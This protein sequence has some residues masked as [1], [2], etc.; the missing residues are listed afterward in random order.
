MEAKIRQVWNPQIYDLYAASESIAMA[1]KPPGQAAWKVLNELQLIEVL[2]AANRQVGAGEIGRTVLTNWTNRVLPLIRY[3]LTDYVICGDTRPGHRT[4]RGFV[5]R[6]YDVLPIRLDDGRA[7]E[8]PSYGLAEFGIAGLEAFQF[9]SLSPDEVEVHYRAGEDL[10]GPLQAEMARLLATWGGT[11]TRFSQRR[12]E[13]LWNDYE[14]CKLNLVRHPDQ[15]QIGLA[16]PI[17]IPNPAVVPAAGLRPGGGFTGFPRTRLEESI[18]AVF[19][20]QVASRPDATAITEGALRLTY[21]ELNRLAN[22]AAHALRASGLELAHPVLLLFHHQA[23]MITAMLGVLKAGACYVPLDPSHPSARNTAILRE[24]GASRVLTDD[25]SLDSARSYGF[26]AAQIINMDRLDQSLADANLGLAIP[27]DAPACILHTSGTICQY[28]MNNQSR[29]AESR[30]P[31]GFAVQ[32]KELRLLDDE[33]RQVAD[34]ATGEMVVASAYLGPGACGPA[35]LAAAPP[36]GRMRVIHTGDLAYRTRDGC[37]VLVGRK[38]WQIKLRGQR[39]NLLEIEQALLTLE[40]VAAA[41]VILQ[42]GEDGAAFL[43]AFV[44]AKAAPAPAA[45]ALRRGLRA[46]LPEAMIPAVFLFPDP[47]PRTAGGK[48]D[49]QALPAAKRG[50]AA[51]QRVAGA[52]LTPTELALAEIW[53]DLLGTERIGADDGF[54]DLGGDS[55]QAAV[56]MV[57]LEARFH[58]RLPLAALIQHGTLRGLAGELA[59]DER[60][61][62]HG[63]LV[64]IQPLGDYPPV[65]LFPGSDGEVLE[66]RKMVALLGTRH[67]LY[68]LSGGDFGDLVGNSKSIEQTAAQYVI[69]IQA[70]RPCGPYI[71]AWDSTPERALP[72][73]IGWSG[74]GRFDSV[75]GGIL[76]ARWR[77][78][79]AGLPRGGIDVWL[80]HAMHLRFS[81]QELATLVEMVSLAANVASWN[82][83]ESA[84]TQIATYEALESKILER[85][86]QAGLG[87]W[88]E[89]DEEKQMF[90]VRPEVEERL[91]FHECYEEFRNESFWEELAV[92]LADRDL[93]RA[94]GMAAWERLSEEERR[95]RTAAWEKRYWEEFSK[96]GVDHMAVVTPPG[97]G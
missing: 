30:V 21:A 75:L 27:A 44:Q 76:A 85:A 65:F 50:S 70:A 10:D 41:A 33:G 36:P 74:Q 34:G 93:A 37:F 26:R 28:F 66:L 18:M 88:I 81:D 94:I 6:S 55:L 96:H 71:L 8:I 25:A 54:F 53:Q 13:Q 68:G 7:G 40:N 79:V 92:R 78:S 42:P 56:L 43:A 46:L 39:M 22:R 62:P 51:S 63:L 82:Q 5:G 91:F 90:R 95:T 23:A 14:S 12:V 2:D 52:P 16:A 77:P 48:I 80:R 69:E 45:D 20:R 29:V 1:V 61:G 32:D 19:E 24:T 60:P 58:R 59:A 97:E 89:F 31:V 73:R 3:E 15:P 35:G 38:D 49:R 64:T 67:P 57:R 4:L 84:D 72:P 9:V 17:S 87:G 11:R 86:G 83:K 47:F